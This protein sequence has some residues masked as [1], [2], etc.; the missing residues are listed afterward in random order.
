MAVSF[1]NRASTTGN[2]TWSSPG[3]VVNSPASVAEGDLL[4][5]TVCHQSNA[6]TS[7]N[8]P[9]GW[10]LAIADAIDFS[11][12]AAI[13]YKI[14]GS[15]EPSTWT[16]TFTTTGNPSVAIATVSRWTGHDASTPINVS[17]SQVNASSSSC[18][19]PSIT[20]TV[21]GCELLF[22]GWD[23]NGRSYTPPTGYNE[24][25]EERIN[26]GVNDVSQSGAHKTQASDGATGSVFATLNAATVNSGFHLAIAP[27]G[28]AAPVDLFVSSTAHSHTAENASLEQ[29][30]V[31][32][33]RA[34]QHGHNAEQASLT[35]LHVLVTVDCLHS[36]LADNA[37]LAQTHILLVDSN[38]HAHLADNVDL[39]QIHVLT[40]DGTEHGHLAGNIE[41]IQIHLLVPA[42]T[43]HSQEAGNVT[44]I[45]DAGIVTAYCSV[46]GQSYAPGSISGQSQTAGSIGSQFYVGGS[47]GG[48][49]YEPGSVARQWYVGGSK[50]GQG[51]C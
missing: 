40:V 33:V 38:V 35:Q 49:C 3:M 32:D 13:F 4:I 7:I 21:D 14:A 41:L 9:S 50:S 8:T 27:D 24:Q 47:L 28:A 37:D 42:N 25:W 31:L 16:L 48:Q 19:A 10:T 5:M 46:A 15:S 11:R 1:Q 34:C 17:G 23:H 45:V 12:K 51:G 30:H 29:T 2:F 18:T 22:F 39:S 26:T 36:H 6:A 20:T 44:L 43:V